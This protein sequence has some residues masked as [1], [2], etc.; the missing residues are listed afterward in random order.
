[1][2]KDTD[3]ME[4]YTQWYTNKELFEMLEGF[5]GDMTDLRLEM[6]ETKTLIRDYNGLRETINSVNER[7]GKCE[8]LLDESKDIR[9]EYIGYIFAILSFIFILLN[10]LK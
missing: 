4:K 1:M 2:E 9:K 3:S 5:K 6:K 8:K 7:V 10:Y